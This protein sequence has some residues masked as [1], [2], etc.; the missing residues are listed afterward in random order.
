[1][2]LPMC[3]NLSCE[4]YRGNTPVMV[5]VFPCDHPMISLEP[6]QDGHREIIGSSRHGDTRETSRLR[7]RRASASCPQNM[8]DML[9]LDLF[10]IFCPRR[11]ATSYFSPNSLGNNGA[12]ATITVILLWFHCGSTILLCYPCTRLVQKVYECRIYRQCTKAHG[13]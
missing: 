11:D 13:R 8:F 9:P 12:R 6:R 2:T 7:E 1:M 5:L 10:P 4:E 3:K